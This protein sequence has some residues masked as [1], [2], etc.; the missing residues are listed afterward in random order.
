[1]ALD[2]LSLVPAVASLYSAYKSSQPT[3]AETAQAQAL[4]NQQYY[5][6]QAADPNSAL[7]TGY[8]N[9]NKSMLDNQFSGTINDLVNSNRRL[10][11]NGQKPLFDAERG[12]QQ[13]L[14]AENLGYQQNADL[15]RQQASSTITG[16]A[17]GAGSLATGYGNSVAN[18]QKRQTQQN[19]LPVNEAN[20][21]TSILSSLFNKPQ[22]AAAAPAAQAPTAAPTPAF[23]S[24]RMSG[25]YTPT[26]GYGDGGFNISGLNY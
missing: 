20:A 3:A 2:F 13:I 24:P 4:A 8:T 11:T 21:G 23:Q 26:T 10:V 5:Q 7:M 18:A 12:D 25:G 1:M 19:F 9:A 22:P 16:L 14:R 6:Q 17:S 15:A